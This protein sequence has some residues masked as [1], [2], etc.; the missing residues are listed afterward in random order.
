MTDDFGLHDGGDAVNVG[1]GVFIHL[2]HAEGFRKSDKVRE[3]DGVSTVLHLHDGVEVHDLLPVL[4]LALQLV[5]VNV[6]GMFLTVLFLFAFFIVVLLL[7]VTVLIFFPLLAIIL[8]FP[9]LHLLL[10][11]R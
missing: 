7:A 6:G 8:L 5:P 4:V 1:G 2:G 9:F 3:S 10:L 11:W